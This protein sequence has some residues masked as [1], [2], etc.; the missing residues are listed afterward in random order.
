MEATADSFPPE[1]TTKYMVSKLL[2]K[3]SARRSNLASGC[4]TCTVLPQDSDPSVVD[5][6]YIIILEDAIDMPNFLFIVLGLP[7]GG[8]LFYKII[9]KTKLNKAKAKLNFLKIALALFSFVF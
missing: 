6:L 5:P 9:K 8:E 7:E 1:L 4:Q 2:E 3:G